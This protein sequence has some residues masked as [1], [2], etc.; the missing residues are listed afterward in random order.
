MS[1]KKVIVVNAEDLKVSKRGR[2]KKSSNPNS[3]RN[4]PEGLKKNTPRATQLRKKLLETIKQHQEEALREQQAQQKNE[5]ENIES[6]VDMFEQDFQ[7]SVNYLQ[8]VVDDHTQKQ[9]KNK[10]LKK[11]SQL[12]SSNANQAPNN[13]VLPQNTMR[14]DT[15]PVQNQMLSTPI[16]Q[17]NI[18]VNINAKP[19]PP[20][21]CLKGGSKPTYKQYHQNQTMKHRPTY[22]QPHLPPSMS[23]GMTTQMIE[24]A[25]NLSQAESTEIDDR[26][27][28]LQRMK[29]KFVEKEEEKQ[30]VEEMQKK[31]SSMIVPHGMKKKKYKVTKY[32]KTLKVGKMRDKHRVGI[33]LKNRRTIK[34]VKHELGILNKRSMSDVKTFLKKR[35]FIKTGTT[36]PP[37][38][39][40]EIYKAIHLTGN[41]KNK[42]DNVFLYNYL[43][44]DD[45]E[46]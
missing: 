28:A 20:Y 25:Y 32:S 5:G 31:Q 6:K 38:I 29:Q 43:Y 1:D 3:A 33:A 7:K 9:T 22:Q 35:N 15:Q 21:G 16:Q 4:K 17:Q 12:P 8:N 11:Y 34:Q 23:I 40:K 39:L 36:A 13:S 27:N 2:K 42:A 10:T 19:P 46:E 14:I 37:H 41:V 44:G 26:R 18:N 45:K 30:R 24:N